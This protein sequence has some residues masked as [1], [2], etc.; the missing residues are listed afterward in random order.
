MIVAGIRAV[1]EALRSSRSQVERVWVVKGGRGKRLQ[2]VIDLAR[3]LQV[4]VQFEPAPT[5]SRIGKTA[6]PPRVVARLGA[7]G[8]VPLEDVMDSNLLLL[9]DGV[10]D[11]RN[12][13]ALLRTAEATGVGGVVIPERRSCG[14]SS[15]VVQTSAGAALHLR[16]VRA[17]NSVKALARL[18]QAGFWVLGLDLKG[19]EDLGQIDL[20]GPLVVVVGGEHSGLRPAVRGACDFLVALPMRGQVRSLN[21]SVA[22]GV[23][24][25]Q[26]VLARAK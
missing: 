2:T 20:T 13:G 26:I 22:A 21:L 24:L 8:T 14:L 10:E 9:A 5:I 12:L 15:T 23:V 18:K 16:L 4:P 6:R 25:Y 3:S 1:N 19:K 17:T 7:I 11:P